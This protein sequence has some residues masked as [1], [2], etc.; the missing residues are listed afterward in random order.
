MALDEIRLRY[1]VNPHQTFARLF[2]PEGKLPITILSAT[3]SYV[4]ILDALNSWQLVRELKELTGQPS[5]ASFKHTSPLGAAIGRPLS[6]ELAQSCFVSG[7]EL[8]PLSCA[9]ARARGADRMSAFG[10]WAAFSDIVDLPT[11]QLLSREISD[12]CIAPG[13]EPEALE[14]LK[15]KKSG[16]YPIIQIDPDYNPP[17]LETRQLFG[18]FLEQQRNT[19]RITETLLERMVTVKRAISEEAKL[20]MLIAFLTMKYTQSN[21]VCL[22]YDGQVIGV[23]AGQQSRIHCT[24]L[25]CQKADRWFLRLHP[26]VLNLPFKKGISR[27]EKANA[28]DLYLE[29]DATEEEL[30]AW[31]LNFTTVPEPLTKDE[32]R[33]WISRFRDV[34]LASDG[35]IPFRD[36]IDRAARS[37]VSYIIQPGGSNRDSGIIRAA[38]EYGMVM[39]FTGLRLFYH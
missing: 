32:K 35:F 24:R 8:S 10:D 36:N 20:N 11:A 6:P 16:Y 23:G 13:Y 12:G 26:K 28:I 31:R 17:E 39:V 21:S 38:D 7:M 9:Y 25:A 33:A 5:A 2:V 18:I 27:G 14:L 37:G 15:K 3:P 1:G 22:A 29:D 19:A 30:Q 4:N 34:V